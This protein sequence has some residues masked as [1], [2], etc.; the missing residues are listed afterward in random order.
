MSGFG[1]LGNGVL[2]SPERSC[3]PLW[4]VHIDIDQHGHATIDI[5]FK[6]RDRDFD[7]NNSLRHDLDDD[8]DRVNRL[9]HNYLDGHQIKHQHLD[10]TIRFYFDQ[11]QYANEHVYG[12]ERVVVLGCGRE[13]YVYAKRELDG[14]EYLHV[15]N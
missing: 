6:C 9:D 8:Y 14:V 12:N 3:H 4:F 15:I 7:N 5:L 11:H 2:L 10:H 1:D 13:L